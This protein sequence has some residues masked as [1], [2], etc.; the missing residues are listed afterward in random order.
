MGSDALELKLGGQSE[1]GTHYFCVDSGG[2]D[3]AKPYVVP[4]AGTEKNPFTWPG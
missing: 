4:P 2:R 1:K 3:G